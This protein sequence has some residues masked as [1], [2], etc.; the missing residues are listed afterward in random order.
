VTFFG[1]DR[2]GVGQPAA[3]GQA[4]MMMDELTP[5]VEAVTFSSGEPLL[6]SFDTGANRSAFYARYYNERRQEFAKAKRSKRSYG[7]AGGVKIDEAYRLENVPME[8]CG[9]RLTLAAVDVNTEPTKKTEPEFYGN[10]GQDI[11]KPF[12]SLT[13]DFGTMRCSVE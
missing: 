10:L 6:F 4:N 9:G 13:I 2:F 8:I 3:S 5:L 7:G 12:R 1:D 11:L